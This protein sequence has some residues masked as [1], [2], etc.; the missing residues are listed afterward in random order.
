M[1]DKHCEHLY[2][3]KDNITGVAQLRIGKKLIDQ[4]LQL[5]YPLKLHCENIKTTNEDEKKNE[6]NPSSMGYCPKGIVAE[7]A[8]WRLKDIAIEKDDGDIW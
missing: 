1:E 7:I 4:A 3:G 5:F 2:I 6:L 8:K